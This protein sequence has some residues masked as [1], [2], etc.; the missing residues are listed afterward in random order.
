MYDPFQLTLSQSIS[1]GIFSICFFVFVWLVAKIN[2]LF[3][4]CFLKVKKVK[5]Y[6]NIT[7]DYHKIRH[8]VLIEYHQQLEDYLRQMKN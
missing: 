6:K 4:N 8:C 3:L 7:Y 1:L 2:K 5:I